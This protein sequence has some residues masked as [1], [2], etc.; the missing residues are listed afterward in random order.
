MFALSLG[1]SAVRRVSRSKYSFRFWI[2][3]L[4]LFVSA[5]WRDGRA[6]AR[7]DASAV[8]PIVGVSA[9]SFQQGRPVAPGSLVAAFTAGVL[10]GGTFLQATDAIPNTPAF[11]LPTLLGN[12]SAEVHGRSVG[13]VSLVNTPSYDQF[14]ILIPPDLAPGKGPIVIKNSSGQ[15]LAAGEI[16]IAPV[17]PAIFT[18]NS[19]GSGVPAALFIAIE[20]ASS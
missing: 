11:D 5:L 7:A 12:F 17:T 13:I 1:P 18:A 14:N 4:L 16:E 8:S 2:L 15:I 19:A 20:R 10:P 6:S 9:A 3:L